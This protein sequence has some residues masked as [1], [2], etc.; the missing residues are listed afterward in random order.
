MTQQMT[1]VRAKDTADN[2]GTG[3]KTQQ[4]LSSYG[5]RPGVGP[6]AHQVI[7][8]RVSS[9]PRDGAEET[10][11]HPDTGPKMSSSHVPGAEVCR[12]HPQTYDTL[13][14]NFIFWNGR[15]NNSFPL[16]YYFLKLDIK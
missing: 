12:T 8:A 10:A 4:L 16:S 7:Q 6:K 1:L 14:I 2:P 9:T 15:S 11:A 3:P 13:L 5:T